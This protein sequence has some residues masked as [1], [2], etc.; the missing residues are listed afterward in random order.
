MEKQTVMYL[1]K[2][3]PLKA[4]VSL[5]VKKTALVLKGDYILLETPEK[6]EVDYRKPLITFYKKQAKKHIQGRLLHFQPMIRKKYKSFVIESHE[7]RWGSCNS[8]GEL[9]FNW[10]L[11]LFPE[12]AIDYVIVHELCHLEHLN[13]DRSF[14]RLVGKLCPDYKNIMPMLGTEKTR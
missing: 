6:G 1:G 2:H 10:K 7:K 8:N 4:E 11:M 5:D 3:W 9:T 13:H 14:W 12:S